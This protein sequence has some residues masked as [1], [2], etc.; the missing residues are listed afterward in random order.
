MLLFWTLYSLI[1]K[2]KYQGF[3]KNIKQHNRFNTDNNNNN[4]FLKNEINVKL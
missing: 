4:C 1:Q 3:H 2:R